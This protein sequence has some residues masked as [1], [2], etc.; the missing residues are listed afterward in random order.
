LRK[1][2]ALKRTLLQGGLR[3]AAVHR[4]LDGW[5]QARSSSGSTSWPGTRRRYPI[6]R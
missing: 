1:M 3:R 5:F 2:F 6:A 4:R